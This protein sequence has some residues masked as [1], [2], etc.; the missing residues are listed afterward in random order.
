MAT[1]SEAIRETW[2]ELRELRF[3]KAWAAFNIVPDCPQCKG[4]GQ[5]GNGFSETV[6]WRGEAVEVCATCEGR[7]KV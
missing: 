3:R 7:G 4:S 5:P 1:V 6:Y 2:G